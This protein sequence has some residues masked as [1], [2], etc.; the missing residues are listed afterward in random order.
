M[1]RV[2]SIQDLSCLGKCSLTVAMPVLSAMGCCC[3]PL[4]TAL[5]ST[6]TA[7]PDPH[8]VPLTK[9]LLP[10]CRHWQQIGAGFDG[11]TV[12]YLSDPEQAA[13]VAEILDMFPALTV[14]DPV[15]G[16]HGNRY[17]RIGDG[18]IE[19][20][21]QLCKKGTFLLPNITEA[22]LLTG[23]PYRPEHDPVYCRELLDGMSRFGAEA[24]V[25]TGVEE[26]PD[27]LGFVGK[28]GKEFFSY[29]AKRIPR[30]C[31]GTGDLFTAVFTGSLLAGCTVPEAGKKAA[32]F[33]ARVIQNTPEAS[34]FGICFEPLLHLL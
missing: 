22:A 32:D 1:K 25:I 14:I 26:A 28:Q 16:D 33:A 10:I 23:L 24:V 34:P 19:A 11:I 20:M 8:I 15:M 6:H 5:L 7:F 2:L 17:R 31:H 30:Q 21:K 3:T 13:T 12:G 18:H 9:E 4:P 27:T 29:Q